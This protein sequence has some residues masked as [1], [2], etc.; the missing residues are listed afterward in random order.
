MENH[1][2]NHMR[3][4]LLFHLMNTNWIHGEVHS[5]E[6]KLL[7]RCQ[8]PFELEISIVLQVFSL[9]SAL[10][11]FLRVFDSCSWSLVRFF[12]TH[13]TS[14]LKNMCCFCHLKC[15]LGVIK[16]ARAQQLIKCQKITSY[17]HL[18]TKNTSRNSEIAILVTVCHFLR[19]NLTMIPIHWQ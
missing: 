15:V 3:I 11:L 14:H 7:H 2:E 9:F 18:K 4:F 13:F 16:L 6:Y 10:S 8:S 19:V 12:S 1:T 17:F 5:G